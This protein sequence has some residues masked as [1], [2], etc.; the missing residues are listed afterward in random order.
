MA[1]TLNNDRS[2]VVELARLLEEHKATE[3]VVMAVA[4]ACTWT[5]YF[6]IATPRSETH[7]RSLVDLV[8]RFLKGRR[9]ATLNGARTAAES[10]WALI[11][12]GNFVIHIMD[13]ERREFY[14]LE[15]LW[16]SSQIV[17]SSSSS[18]S[19]SS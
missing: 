14:E 4:P 1:D 18:S 8:L 3:A 10:G 12:C 11:D 17:Y 7:L 2:L 15:K 5:D 13:R 6:V 16:F 19:S 9:A